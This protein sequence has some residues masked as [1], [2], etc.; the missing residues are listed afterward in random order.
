MMNLNKNKTDAKS[1][2]QT[3]P[4]ALT[5]K[6]ILKEDILFPPF[7]KYKGEKKCTIIETDT[8]TF[9]TREIEVH[10]CRYDK[11]DCVYKKRKECVLEYKKEKE[12]TKSILEMLRGYW[13]Y[14]NK[15]RMKL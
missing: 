6:D 8:K 14:D 10:D 15:R 9:N 7:C 13:Q 2:Q 4:N 5:G 1:M 12:D 3:N 11:N